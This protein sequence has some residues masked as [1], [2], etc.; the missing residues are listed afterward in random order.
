MTINCVFDKPYDIY[1]E[2]NVVG[3]TTGRVGPGVILGLAR[4]NAFPRRRSCP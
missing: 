2:T 4:R 1:L 3:K